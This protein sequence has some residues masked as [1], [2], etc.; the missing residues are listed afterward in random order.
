MDIS[1]FE[2]EWKECLRAHYDHVVREHDE[3][4]EASLISVLIQ[5]GFTQD[6]I[7]L[8]RAGIVASLDWEPKSESDDEAWGEPVEDTESGHEVAGDLSA[9]ATQESTGIELF[10]PPVAPDSLEILEASQTLE[11]AEVQDMLEEEEQAEDEP[12]EPE[13][14]TQL[15]MF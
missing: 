15:S 3:N 7:E 9:F 5:T 12:P 13:G 10:E 4:N 8:M 14:F 11:T 6:E 2:D 1:L